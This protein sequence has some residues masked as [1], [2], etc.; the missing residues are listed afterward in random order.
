VRAATALKKVV[1]RMK[2]N[3]I[4]F[5]PMEPFNFSVANEDSNCYSFDMRKVR[6]VR[7]G[8]WDGV[9]RWGGGRVDLAC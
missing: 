4:A 7:V 3:A 2:T 5:N 6:A 1:L 8:E 9:C